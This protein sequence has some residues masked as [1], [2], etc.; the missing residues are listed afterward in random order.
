MKN[1]IVALSLSKADVMAHFYS[2]RVAIYICSCRKKY[3]NTSIYL[4]GWGLKLLFSE[5]M[6]SL[7]FPCV[8]WY[9]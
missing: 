1:N 4:P 7:L 6:R 2:Y 9:H 3:L 5:T 8:S